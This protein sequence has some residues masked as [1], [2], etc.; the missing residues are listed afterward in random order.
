MKSL[1]NCLIV[2]SM[3]LVAVGCT[4]PGDESTATEPTPAANEE[5]N[6]NNEESADDHS[7][8]YGKDVFLTG[9]SA[10]KIVNKTVKQSATKPLDVRFWCVAN[11][12]PE[13]TIS[14]NGQAFEFTKGHR[15]DLDEQYSNYKYRNGYTVTIPANTLKDADNNLLI[16]VNGKTVANMSFSLI[17]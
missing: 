16:T 9:L 12:E 15:A 13:V 8:T 10:P 3:V 14:V 4:Q 1:M 17:P 7:H 5:A 6:E 2:L 11:A